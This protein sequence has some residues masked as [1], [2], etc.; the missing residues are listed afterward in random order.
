MPR[1]IYI[2]IYKAL[3]RDTVDSLSH[4]A[5]IQAAATL[6]YIVEHVG[7]CMFVPLFRISIGQ[8]VK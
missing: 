1:E 3:Q 2:Y 4:A 6:C 5:S 7:L 8:A